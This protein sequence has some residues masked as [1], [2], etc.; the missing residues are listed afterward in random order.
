MQGP[1]KKLVIVG[2]STF[3]VIYITVYLFHLP[4]IDLE[5]TMKNMQTQAQVIEKFGTPAHIFYSGEKDY[6]SKGYSYEERE[7][8]HKVSVYSSYETNLVPNDGILYI[9][10]SEDGSIEHYYIGDT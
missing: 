3:I 8:S 1:V 7:I 9:Y 5:K 4:F 6:Y 2:A 10:Y